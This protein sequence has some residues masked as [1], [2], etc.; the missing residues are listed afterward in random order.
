M[1]TKNIHAYTLLLVPFSMLSMESFKSFAQ[2]IQRRKA[3]ITQIQSINEKNKE[4][5]EH[6]IFYKNCDD[7]L[8][9]ISLIKDNLS[10]IQK[11]IDQQYKTVYKTVQKTYAIDNMSWEH[12]RYSFKQAQ[13][14]NIFDSMR[15]SPI[16]KRQ[17]V[18]PSLVAMLKKSLEKVYIPEEM[19]EFKYSDEKFDTVTPL[20]HYKKL[21]RYLD[22]HTNEYASITMHKKVSLDIPLKAKEGLCLIMSSQLKTDINILKLG[23]VIKAFF[24]DIPNQQEFD[25][26]LHPIYNLDLLQLAVEDKANAHALKSYYTKVIEPNFSLSFYE[27]LCK[28]NQLHGILAWLEKYSS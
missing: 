28:I 24:K 16:T 26:L 22:M 1:I 17:D 11:D 8:A 20:I 4:E 25:E 10:D 2:E 21:K 14:T 5:K 15:F 27:T 7:T 12:I 3:L 18:H 23:F 19:V 6:C 9:E 13:S